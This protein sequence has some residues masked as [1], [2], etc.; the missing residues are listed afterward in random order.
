M[1]IKFTLPKENYIRIPY[2]SKVSDQSCMDG[3]SA[4][5]DSSL[6]RCY[7]FKLYRTS[8]RSGLQ[9]CVVKCL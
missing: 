7:C 4:K 6:K 1:Y 3:K 8:Y 5:F 2:Y 9:V